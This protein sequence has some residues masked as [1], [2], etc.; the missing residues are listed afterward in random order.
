M[1]AL[2]TRPL[3]FAWALPLAAACITA[4]AAAPPKVLVV[5][6]AWGNHGFRDEFD[7]P[8][9]A[10]GWPVEKVENKDVAA[11]IGRLNEFDLV[12]A[13]SV[14]NYENRQ[15][16][17][18]YREAWLAFL[19]RGGALLV[20]DASYDS[21]LDLWLN[22]L[23][24]DWALRSAGC[25]PHT[26]AHGGSAEVTF[27][28][29]SD[30]LRVPNDL[31]AWFGVKD[32]IWA[33]LEAW[34]SGW[35]N[36]ATC[37]DGK[38]LLLTRDHG[39]GAAVVTSWYSFK[40]ANRDAPARALLENLWTHTSALRRGLAL[41]ALDLG[42]P[43][44]GPHVVRCAWQDRR[45]AP[46]PVTARLDL[47]SADGTVASL[48]S[49][50][51][52]SQPGQ[53]TALTLPFTLS[54]RGSLRYR[55]ELR[56]DGMEPLALEHAFTVPPVIGVTLGNRHL[57]PPA[58]RLDLRAE[59]TPEASVRLDD[60]SA[61]ITL[62]GK[63]LTTWTDLAASGT[64]ELRLPPLAPGEHRVDVRLVQG[65][66]ELGAAEVAF[67][68][69]ATPRVGTRPDGVLL[70]AGKPFFPCG[71]YHVSWGFSA[72]ERLTCL[73]TIA[74]GGFNVL[75]ASIRK[76]DMEP[77]DRWRELLDEADRLG[78]KLITEFGADPLAVIQ[79]YREHPA[80][81]A[82]NPG[83]EPDG[84]GVAPAEMA[85]RFDRFKAV[86]PEH[87]TY[88]VLCVPSSYSRYVGCA[89]IIAPDV[90]PVRQTSSR[91]RGV[92]DQLSDARAEAAKYGRPVWG[93]LQCFG[94]PDKPGS[95]R[96]PTY[97]ECRAMTYLA[98]LAGVKGIVYYT[99]ADNGFNMATQ[100]ELWQAMTALPPEIAAITPFLI[101]GQ[102][103]R[104]D[105]GAPDVIGGV[106]T[107]GQRTLVCLVN[108]TAK[109]CDVRIALPAAAAGQE[110][111]P[112]AGRPTTL[113][114]DGGA[115]AGSLAAGGVELLELV[116][117]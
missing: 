105:T 84:G 111:A 113:R 116:R 71:W 35:S 51:V 37:A 43:L 45:A 16:M 98:L 33:H 15:D 100:P 21:V 53:E 26:K 11:W 1:R 115:V 107:L 117:P 49:A 64:Y 29:V 9:K 109:P 99:Y 48:A 78:V 112:V 104:L 77:A 58:E 28:A 10:L 8:L 67:H 102:L 70:V 85:A 44:P 4:A 65:D 94:Y 86:D 75:H 20:V 95:W 62:D 57:Y 80:V 89:E 56:A 79:R 32:S 18:P 110:A 96:I 3:A 14:C 93:V 74:A 91:I 27:D 63:A 42:T 82:W 19:E 30:F 7:A 81:L 25:A 40:R 23:G 36:L 61:A 5:Y 68:A 52:P 101:E 59:F 92:Y 103:A 106:W 60:C 54:R 76:Q 13:T 6:S 24:E 2:L 39:R 12:V 17:Q 22:R 88:M 108:A 47:V 72:D 50:V 31:P 90:Y 87:P 73:R 41:K 114:R 97:A 69:Y 55:L 46:T 38:S 83:D 34:G 66:R